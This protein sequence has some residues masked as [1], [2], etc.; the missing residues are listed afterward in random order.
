M[1][2]PG[3]DSAHGD[4][5]RHPEVGDHFPIVAELPGDDSVEQGEDHRQELPQ[6][7]TL[8]HKDQG[9]D[10]DQGGDQRQKPAPGQQQAGG[11]D[12]KHGAKPDRGFVPG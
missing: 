2:Q 10:A 6:D 4:R 9:G 3:D 5:R 12:Q 7:V 1:A 8:C 11:Q